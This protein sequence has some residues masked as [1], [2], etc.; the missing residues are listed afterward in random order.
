VSV[1]RTRHRAHPGH[2]GIGEVAS[3]YGVTL[4]TLRFYEQK[5]LIRPDRRDS[6]TRSYG[7]DDL[8]RLD[9]VLKLRSIGVSLDDISSLLGRDDEAAIT[10]E[11]PAMLRKR[12]EEIADERVRLAEQDGLARAWLADLDAE[13]LTRTSVA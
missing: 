3:R 4:R 6:W 8:A 1:R 11:L 5:G 2:L 10:A 9:R 7:P 13:P 12:L